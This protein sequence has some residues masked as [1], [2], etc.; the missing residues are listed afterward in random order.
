M[1]V[2]R[3]R[4]KSTGFGFR[5]IAS[6]SSRP[7][8]R[9][10][11]SC[12]A[13]LNFH[14]EVLLKDLIWRLFRWKDSDRILLAHVEGLRPDSPRPR[15]ASPERE[16]GTPAVASTRSRPGL[17]L[18][19]SMSGVHVTN[20]PMAQSLNAG[21]NAL[22]PLPQRNLLEGVPSDVL[23]KILR[24]VSEE[25]RVAV[26][27]AHP[28]LA[29]ST[30]ELRAV[31]LAADARQ[32]STLAQFKALLGLSA[33]DSNSCNLHMSLQ[34]V[35]ASLQATPLRALFGRIPHLPRVDKVPAIVA[36]RQTLLA[37]P[38]P[39]PADIENLLRDT[40]HAAVAGVS[41]SPGPA[42]EAVKRGENCRA[43]AQA[44]GIVG[45][46]S[47]HSLEM[48]SVWECGVP[49]VR[50]GEDPMAVAR[51]LGIEKQEHINTLRGF[52]D[53]RPSLDC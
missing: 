44:L 17:P 50:N 21:A 14:L 43:V 3:H 1:H 41:N 19:D 35:P 2:L 11:A 39:R 31:T 34:A 45:P 47:L 30:P 42:L 24:R 32:V 29:N 9:N 13:Y 27:Q 5:D 37:L 36:F 16:A 6:H 20:N 18:T 22:R 52:F 12:H 26:V 7:T 4:A 40:E 33:D 46:T 38:A 28:S 23:S 25:D 15:A 49:A 8:R 51:R 10:P 53:D 48:S